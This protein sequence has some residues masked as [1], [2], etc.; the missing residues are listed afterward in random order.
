[1][2]DSKME[3][4]KNKSGLIGKIIIHIMCYIDPTRPLRKYEYDQIALLI[5][6]ILI[7]NR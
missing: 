1:M 7:K 4:A 5:E 6:E 2:L 3:T